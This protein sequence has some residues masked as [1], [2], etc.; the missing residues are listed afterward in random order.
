M[1]APFEEF[2]RALARYPA[3]YRCLTDAH[4]SDITA[5]EWKVLGLE[6]RDRAEN[7]TF[8]PDPPKRINAGQG[9]ATR[10]STVAA[11]VQFDHDDPLKRIPAAEYLPLIAGV[12]VS[13]SGRCRCPMPDHEDLHPSARLTVSGGCA[14]RAGRAGRSS[15][16]LPQS[17]ASLRPDPTTGNCATGSSRPSRGAG[18]MSDLRAQ[19]A[20]YRARAQSNG[21]VPASHL[22]RFEEI[23][24]KPVRWAW[25]DRAALAKITALAG[26]PKIGKGLLYS[27]LIA[28]VTRGELAGDLD[29]PRDAVIVTTEDEPGDTLKP[30]LMAAGADLSRVSMFQMGAKDAPVPFRVPQDADELGRRVGDREAALV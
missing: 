7:Y 19:E 22:I 20:D 29:G 26:R 3:S 14:S 27:H 17:T 2:Q 6:C 12:E 11:R 13:S 28:A 24:A 5:R 16:W 4:G 1:T 23:V 9:T 30:R 18:S 21:D 10:T 8:E 25:Q 15:T